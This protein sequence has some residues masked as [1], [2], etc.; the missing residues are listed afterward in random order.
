MNCHHFSFTKKFHQNVF[1]QKYFAKI[2]IRQTFRP[3]WGRQFQWICLHLP[4][5][6][7]GFKSHAHHLRFFHY[8][9]TFVLYLSF[10]EKSTK[11]NKMMP[12]LAPAKK[13][14]QQDE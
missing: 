10:V 5:F 8:Y 7:T 13:L 3:I 11:I 9:S 6:C 1:E 14:L 4:F 2:L 12:G